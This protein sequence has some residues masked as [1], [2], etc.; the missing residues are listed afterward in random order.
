MMPSARS[1]PS[2]S[3]AMSRRGFLGLGLGAG[4]MFALGACG[5]SSGGGASGSGG[6]LKWAWQLP[7]SWDP[8]TSSAGSDVQMHALVYD[9]ITALDDSG[10]AVPYLAE[11]WK[12][13]HDGTA[14]RF[15]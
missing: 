6:T 15:T 11:S 13:N 2:D 7:T 3:N 4:A 14:E 12:S 9:A 1:V 5:A 8:V 10:K